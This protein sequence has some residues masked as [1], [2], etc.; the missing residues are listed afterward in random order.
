MEKRYL[1]LG[2]TVHYRSKVEKIIV[3][4]NKAVGVKLA[5]GTEHRADVIISNADG[6]KTIME[7]LEGKYLD[8][9]TRIY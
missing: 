6:R 7:M 4:N 9:K 8:A 3:E 1:D 2:G 5:D